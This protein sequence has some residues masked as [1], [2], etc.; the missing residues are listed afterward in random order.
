MKKSVIRTLRVDPD[1][2]EQVNHALQKRD[3]TFSEAV[4]QGLRLFLDLHPYSNARNAHAVREQSPRHEE[5]PA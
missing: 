3:L 4:R 1:F 5:A 2:S